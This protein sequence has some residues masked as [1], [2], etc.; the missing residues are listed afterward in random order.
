MSYFTKEQEEKAVALILKECN[1]C[2]DGNENG[3]G[4]RN[5]AYVERDDDGYII[6]NGSRPPTSTEGIFDD[7]NGGNSS[8]QTTAKARHWS[9]PPSIGYLTKLRKLT[10]YHCK[11]LPIEIVYLSESLQEIAFHFCDELDFDALPQEFNSLHQ[12]IDFRIHGRTVKPQ[13]ILP[14][15]RLQTFSNLRYLYYRGGASTDLVDTEK[16]QTNLFLHPNTD[17][18]NANFRLIQDLL[19]D[20]IKFKKSLEILE[21]EGGDLDEYTVASLFS[22]V[23]PQYPN[24]KRL[25]LPNNKIRTLSP[26]IAQQPPVIPSTVRLKC[27]YLMGNPVLDASP[28]GNL[29]PIIREKKNLQR[30]LSLFEEL[31]SLGHGITES[32]LCTTKMLLALDLNDGGKILLSERF[33]PIPLSVWPIVLER[34]S[35]RKG[36]YESTN[37]LFHLLRNGP[38]LGKRTKT[39]SPSRVSP[40]LIAAANEAIPTAYSVVGL[41]PLSKFSP[42]CAIITSRSVEMTTRKRKI[43]MP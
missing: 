18:A 26:I 5:M 30:L 19:R 32:S 38:A 11:S 9:M 15:H 3:S 22:L 31:S 23:L 21:I 37:V 10:V 36:Y 24:L 17:I 13:R 42:S 6:V 41:S 25:I 28:N 4:A 2:D 12:L 14:I 33:K 16:K 40:L 27:F 43:S 20:E 29:L 35:Q 34:V 39:V 1:S 7:E 8:V